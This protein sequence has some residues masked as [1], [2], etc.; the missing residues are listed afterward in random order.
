MQNTSGSTKILSDLV[1]KHPDLVVKALNKND[2]KIDMATA[3]LPKINEMLFTALYMDQNKKLASDIDQLI[4][5]EG[6]SNIVPLVLAG[7]SLA[8][9]LVGTFVGKSEAKKQRRLLQDIA[10]ADLANREKIEFENIRTQAETDRIKILANTLES[11]RTTLQK[12]STVRLKDTWIY[13][14]GTG[15]IMSI[16]YGLFLI[17]SKK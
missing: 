9:S 7:V 3:T 8:S 12:E 6:Y 14:A 17:K 5:N 1:Y 16:F 10:L 11:Y 13:I 15:I 4:N 2:Y